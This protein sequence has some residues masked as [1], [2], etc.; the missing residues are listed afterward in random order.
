M[1]LMTNP[2]RSMHVLIASTEQLE[3][4]RPSGSAT[5]WEAAASRIHTDD[6]AR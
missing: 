2:T 5:H 4:Y 1:E 6:R 3:R